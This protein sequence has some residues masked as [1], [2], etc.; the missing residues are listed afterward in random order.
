MLEN[1]MKIE[2]PEEVFF[3]YSIPCA[4]E[5]LDLGTINDEIHELILD[6]AKKK[7]TPDREFL[8]RAYPAA[9][10]RIEKVAERLGVNKWNVLA[11]RKYF[12]ENHNAVIDNREGNYARI[13]PRSC[14][15]CKVRVGTVVGIENTLGTVVY[16]IDY[17][18]KR[19]FALGTYYNSAAVGD[20]IST[21]WRIAV[22]KIE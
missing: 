10:K 12:L 7:I 15:L 4:R 11:I 20:R 17:G 2:T 21:H 5:L 6:Y 19:D 22:E 13:L 8:E 16:Q 9:L 3:K 1:K 18:D 14:E